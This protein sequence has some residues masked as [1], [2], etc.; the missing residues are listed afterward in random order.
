MKR[1]TTVL[2]GG[3]PSAFTHRLIMLFSGQSTSLHLQTMLHHNQQQLWSYINLQSSQ[4]SSLSFSLQNP[5][6]WINTLNPWNCLHHDLHHF[7]LSPPSIVVSKSG[8]QLDNFSSQSCHSLLILSSIHL[9][10]Q[11][12]MV[13]VM[14]IWNGC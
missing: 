10:R 7:Y 6:F 8:F 9:S 2:H 11:N 5:R 3:A 4:K 1:D 14:L 13:E 12:Y